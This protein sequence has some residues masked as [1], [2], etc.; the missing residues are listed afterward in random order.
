MHMMT[1]NLGGGLLHTLIEGCKHL[2]LEELRVL[3][4]FKDNDDQ[5]WCW[6]VTHSLTMLA[7]LAAPVIIT[8]EL[9]YYPP[10]VGHNSSPDDLLMQSPTYYPLVYRSKV[11]T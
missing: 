1:T 7:S 8:G 10:C 11:V 5:P 9:T 3:K 2:K 4:S 6:A